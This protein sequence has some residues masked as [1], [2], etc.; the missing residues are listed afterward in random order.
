[1]ETDAKTPLPFLF[2]HFITG[3]G[4]RSGIVGNGNGSRINGCTKTNGSGN[5]KRK[6][7]I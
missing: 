1:M 7:V 5:I 2:P 6:L 3:N 4:I